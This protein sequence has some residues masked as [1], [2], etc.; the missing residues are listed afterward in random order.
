MVR[1]A[2]VYFVLICIPIIATNR[3]KPTRNVV[4]TA[5]EEKVRDSAGYH[6]IAEIHR[7]MDDDHSGSID[8][9]E[10]SGFMTE[11]MHMRSS[12]RARRENTFH[13]DD[14]AITVDDLW[15]A[16][17]ESDE[18]NW[19][20]DQLVHWIVD[21][22]NLPMYAEAIVKQKLD[23]SIL[24]R[25]AVQNTTFMTQK[26]G[27]KSSV[28]KQKLRL[29][30]L[31]VVLFGFRDSSSK[32]K[33]IA[34]GL[35]LLT[36]TSVLILYARQRKRAEEESSALSTKMDQLKNME[37]DFE[38]IQKT[39]AE[40]RSKRS[41]ADGGVSSS[42]VENL[43]VKL[44]A[45][46]RRLEEGNTGEAP[47]ALQ[48]LLR[49][50]CENEM[51]FLEKQRQE[52]VKEM[53]DAIEMVDRLQK[54]QSSVLSSLKLATGAS[55]ASDQVDSKIFA[56]KSRM[57]KIQGLTRDTQDRWLQI[58]TL[59]EFPILFMNDTVSS[60]NGSSNHQFYRSNSGSSSESS[61]SMGSEIT[62]LSNG[63]SRPP[64]IAQ[65][66]VPA[67]LAAGN[68]ENLFIKNAANDASHFLSARMVHADSQLLKDEIQPVIVERKKRNIF[69]K[70]LKKS[71][72]KG[73]ISSK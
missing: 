25:L 39:L 48:P 60:K 28:H 73:S 41:T 2:L 54:K 33:D 26:L 69:S 31:D 32:T 20:T 71:S 57:E 55:T 5:E 8:R 72:S 43:R 42:E 7:E 70:L 44:L 46:E 17:F 67:F 53:K 4:V 19:T 59:C 45:A 13:G 14:D 63:V 37:T 49:K 6:A 50:T 18:R 56:L 52:C 15:E 9:K 40:E 58:E 16:W 3:N 27:I 38:N 23:G 21:V 10:T 35:L 66:N 61:K 47:R 65:Q 36:L 51:A 1:I 11:D 30:S 12:D 62:S 22:V 29:N 24:P 34:L 68:T 64:L